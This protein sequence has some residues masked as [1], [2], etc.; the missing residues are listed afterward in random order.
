MIAKLRTAFE[1]IERPATWTARA[2]WGMATLAVLVALA[3]VADTA[4]W[5]VRTY[6]SL[7]FWDQWEVVVDY[8]QIRAGTFGADDLI[9]QHGE[10]RIVFPRLVFYADAL[11]GRGQNIVNLAVIAAIQLLHAAVLIRVLGPLRRP[12]VVAAAAAV[13][14]LL[15]FLGQWENL[16]WGFQVQFVAVYLLA[17]CAYLALA[18]AVAADEDERPRAAAALFAGACVLLVVAMFSMANGMA[19]AGVAVLLALVLRAP[20]WMIV[21]LIVVTALCVALYMRGYVSVPDHS[22]LEYALAHP[23][24]YLNYVAHY[25]GNVAGLLAQRPPTARFFTL[26]ATGPLLL[27]VAGLALAAT[28]LVRETRARFADPT[29]AV[30]LAVM[31]FVLASAALTA[32]GRLNFGIDQAHASRYQTPGA[33][34]WAAQVVYWTRASNAWPGRARAFSA[35]VLAGLFALLIWSQVRQGPIV[36]M[37]AIGMRSAEDA[38]RSRVRDDAALGAAYFRPGE[39]VARAQVLDR[40]DL[41][42]FAQPEADWVGRKLESVARR[43]PDGACIGAFDALLAPPR[44]APDQAVAAGWVWDVANDRLPRRVVMINAAGEVVGFGTTGIGRPD[45]QAARAEV[46]ARG[47]GWTGFA[48]LDGRPVEALALLS[49]GTACGIGVLPGLPRS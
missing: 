14:A 31:A 21:T 41:S 30:L 17:T 3:I 46:D 16:V 27:G 15:T 23:V 4:G 22:S 34:F 45:V 47:S 10:H 38:L 40:Y 32:L 43:A 7:P 49:D 13:L 48:R 33:V 5:V 8:A 26:L 1:G 42:I 39:A 25:V 11:F 44:N 20:R 29:Q 18:R 6:S 24:E 28:A 19:A 35:V 9:D 36:D 37:H 12:G 2:A